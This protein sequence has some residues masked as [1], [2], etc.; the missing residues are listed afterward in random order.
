[1]LNYWWVTRPKRK[2]NSIPEELAAFC[3]I[4]LGK[5][6]ARNRESHIAFEVE[7]EQSEIKRIGERRDASGSGGRTHAVMLFSLGLWF[8]KDEKVYLTLAGESIMEGNPPVPILKK[9]VLRFQYPSPYSNTIRMSPRFK[10]RPF[11]FL[12]RLLNDDRIQ[13]LRQDEIAFIVAIEATDESNE[14]FENVVNRILRYR[15][16]GNK[17]FPPGYFQKLDA[18]EHNLL[19]IANTIMNWIDYTQLVFREAKM[20]GI[21]EEKKDEVKRILETPIAFIQYPIAADIFQ[22]KF[23]IDPQ[24]LK[25]T[26]NLL[27]TATISSS[28][29][30]QNRIL[31]AFFNYSSLK[32]IN[33]ITSEVVE[34]ICNKT[35]TEYKFTEDILSKKYPC[36]AI[37]GYLSNYRS[38]AFEGRD[39]S[40]DFEVATAN[41]F[42]DTFNYQ[43]IH[44]GQSGA[45]SSPDILII[46]ADAGYQAIIDNKAYSNYSITGDH[47]NR[48]VHNYILGNQN[49]SPSKLPIGFFTYIGGGF[50]PHID[51][52]IQS[53]IEETGTPGSAITVFNLISLIEDHIKNPYSHQELRSIFSIGRKVLLSDIHH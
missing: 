11:I 51:R 35:G 8:E 27:N 21:A 1:M 12:L 39:E 33:K 5:K 52:Q 9:Q 26:R 45:K 14:C 48:M 53:E 50:V 10:I 36:G 7:L 16:E 30:D 22:R 43:A 44:M 15:T 4:A 18:S 47:H 32:P 17:M 40:I 24:H 2:L 37:E 13:V 3:S 20:I 19:D 38:M 29:I 49:Y 42:R 6:W 23:G 31:R 25:D 34:Y 28:M 46:A 41:L